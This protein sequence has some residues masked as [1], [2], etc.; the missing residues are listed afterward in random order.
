[1]ISEPYCDFDG[2][3]QSALLC[4]GC[5]WAVALVLGEGFVTI[6]T[7]GPSDF[8]DIDDSGHRECE[9]CG[10][11]LFPLAMKQEEQE[12]AAMF[13]QWQAQGRPN[14]V[15]EQRLQELMRD[16]PVGTYIALKDD[17][18]KIEERLSQ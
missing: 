11:D 6:T 9:C 4:P 18:D 2:P 17:P 16:D 10:H 12:N 5:G 1:M 15:R 3:M 14:P 8:A 7:G 13:A